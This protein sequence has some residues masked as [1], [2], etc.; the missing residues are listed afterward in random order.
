MR[1]WF[2]EYEMFIELAWSNIMNIKRFGSVLT[3]NPQVFKVVLL[4]ALNSSIH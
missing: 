1:I 4:R 3:K 2:F